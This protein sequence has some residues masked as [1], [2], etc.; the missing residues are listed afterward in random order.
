MQNT[1]I[2]LFLASYI[3]IQI[4]Y[5]NVA[6]L[7]YMARKVVLESASSAYQ[8]GAPLARVSP[9]HQIF[10]SVS[11]TRPNFAGK[12]QVQRRA[13]LIVMICVSI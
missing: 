7:L 3:D 8:R 5:I 2:C 10:C 1:A 4:I 9:F 11:E 12:L 13:P 6:R